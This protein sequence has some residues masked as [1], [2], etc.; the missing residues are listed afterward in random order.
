LLEHLPSDLQTAIHA[1]KQLRN[2]SARPFSSAVAVIRDVAKALAHLHA[3]GIVHGD[4]HSRN[5]FLDR[6]GRAKLGDLG[7][8]RQDWVALSAR[9]TNSSQFDVWCLGVVL[10]QMLDQQNLHPALK[11]QGG[12]AAQD[13]LGVLQRAARVAREAYAPSTAVSTVL[14][15]CTAADPAHRPTARQLVEALRGVR[16]VGAGGA[17]GAGGLQRR[18]SESLPEAEPGPAGLQLA[19]AL[20]AAATSW[21][22]LEPVEHSGRLWGS[23]VRG[24]APG[25]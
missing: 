21:R 22:P 20:R 18:G 5:I 11:N 23:L 2:L 12:R 25:E 3:R 17:G 8:A 1:E 6:N 19:P 13:R 14:R 9:G 7:S 4:V 15:A 24:A 16:D 10:A